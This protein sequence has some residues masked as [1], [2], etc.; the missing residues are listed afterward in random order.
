MLVEIHEMALESAGSEQTESDV[1]GTGEV[2]ESFGC[3]ELLTRGTIL[4]EI[5][6]HLS[7]LQGLDAREV[8]TADDASVQE[9]WGEGFHSETLKENGF[10][11]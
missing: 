6:D 11:T 2:L 1:G 10:E 3:T 4:E 8:G 7:V 9:D 5:D